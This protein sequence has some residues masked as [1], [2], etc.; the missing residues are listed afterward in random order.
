MAIVTSEIREDAV[1]A[2]GRRYIIEV[3]TDH[4]GQE[5]C[6]VWMAEAVQDATA[7]LPS[8]AVWL[9]DYLAQQEIEA[10]MQGIENEG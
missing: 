10:N 6:F 2:D 9:A 7:I 1:Q 8:R 4:T 3:H 5:H